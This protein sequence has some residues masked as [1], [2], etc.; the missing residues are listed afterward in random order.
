MHCPILVKLKLKVQYFLLEKYAS[1]KTFINQLPS[2][3][4]NALWMNLHGFGFGD[5]ITR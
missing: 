3:A 1:S 4:E 2:M 5:Q